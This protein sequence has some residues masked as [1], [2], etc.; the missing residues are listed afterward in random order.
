[1]VIVPVL[2]RAMIS[3]LP[4]SS[5]ASLV[6]NRIPCFAPTPL[7]TIMATGVA[8]PKAHG[9]E[10]TNTVMAL[11][12][13]KVNGLPA[14]SHPAR[15]TREIPIMDG[16]KIPETLSAILATGAFVPAASETS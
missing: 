11:S 6:L 15:T 16:T 5:R 10:M 4:A 1:M 12:R 9:Q 3:T 2:S 7:P 14:I 8:S 13:A